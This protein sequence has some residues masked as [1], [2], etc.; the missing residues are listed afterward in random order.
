MAKIFGKNSEVV[1]Y[2]MYSRLGQAI[3]LQNRIVINS[4]VR[5][6]N[7]VHKPKKAK[8]SFNFVYK[9]PEKAPNKRPTSSFSSVDRMHSFC[10]YQPV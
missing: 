9:T 6:D 2:H 8:K 5:Q 10:K 1:K 4:G 3:K 7:S